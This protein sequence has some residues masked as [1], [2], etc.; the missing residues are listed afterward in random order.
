V[1]GEVRP[2]D[3]IALLEA[4]KDEIAAS[5]V[6]AARAVNAELISMYWRIGALIL[7]R[8]AAQ[9]WGARVIERLAADLRASFPGARGLSR[10]NLPTCGPSPRHG[11]VKCHSLWHNFPG[12]MCVFC[13]TASRTM[14]FDSGTP[15]ET[16]RKGGRAR[17]WRPW[18]PAGCTCGRV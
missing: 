16:P 12:G 17:C 15:P 2:D 3:Y 1:T 18:W 9:G 13:W 6:R 14:R 7:E 5:R 4:V 8:Q 11:R 10:R